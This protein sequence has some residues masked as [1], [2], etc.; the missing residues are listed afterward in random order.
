M[1]FDKQLF[2]AHLKNGDAADDPYDVFDALWK[3]FNVYYESLF[4]REKGPEMDRVHLA[5]QPLDK[6]DYQNFLTPKTVSPLNSIPLVFSERDWRRRANKNTAS[7][8]IAN[9]ALAEIKR[10]V[11]PTEAHVIAMLS[12]LYLIRCNM[13]HGFKTRDD[14]RDIEVLSAANYIFVPFMKTLAE[15]VL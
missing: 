7:H 8:R 13:A 1:T 5:V 14:S 12:L 3:A 11:V 6:S 4:Q 10:G 15:R 2:S 9:S